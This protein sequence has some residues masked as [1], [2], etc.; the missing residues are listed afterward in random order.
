MRWRARLNILILVFTV[1]AWCCVA[2]AY[3]NSYRR[4][5]RYEV[6]RDTQR[7][8]LFSLK[9]Q[10]AIR[11]NNGYT[12][13]TAVSYVN[14][15]IR[16]SGSITYEPPARAFDPDLPY[17]PAAPSMSDRCQKSF[18]GFGYDWVVERQSSYPEWV[19]RQLV[20]VLPYPAVILVLGLV[21]SGW[22][23]KVLRSEI[24]HARRKRNLCE[25]CGYDLR[26]SKDN[27]PECGLAVPKELKGAR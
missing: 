25:R 20:V 12:G 21:G 6:V 23:L 11:W 16:H 2:V 19:G 27:C 26:A 22:A 10:I 13:K 7:V 14:N 8:A 18:A 17:L 9:G 1:V 4:L 5:G 15:G 24:K 3:F